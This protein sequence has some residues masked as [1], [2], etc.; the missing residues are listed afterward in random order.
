MAMGLQDSP[1]QTS[2]EARLGLGGEEKM[3]RGRLTPKAL[4]KD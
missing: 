1:L 3:G 4:L 2:W